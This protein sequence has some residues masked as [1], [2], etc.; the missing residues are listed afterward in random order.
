MLNNPPVPEKKEMQ[1]LTSRERRFL[2]KYLEC[3]HIGNAYLYI[4]PKTKVSNSFASGSRLMKN[5]KT[6][7]SWDQ[8]LEEAGL[9]ETRLMMELDKRLNAEHERFYQDKSLGTFEDNQTRMKATDLLADILGVKKREVKIDNTYRGHIFL[10][11]AETGSLDAWTKEVEDA[12]IV[13]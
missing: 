4:S 9:G 11:P 6:K 5:I 10:I 3:G 1:K 2:I 8:L 13:K 12:E 7:I